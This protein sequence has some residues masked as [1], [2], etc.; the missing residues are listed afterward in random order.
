MFREFGRGVR[1][2]WRGCTFWARR[3]KL[4]LLGLVP[5][6]LAFV[7]LAGAL[8]AWVRVAPSVAT[9]LTPF[10]GL[11]DSDLIAL[12]RAAVVLALVIGAIALFVVVFAALTLL[13]G[14]PVYERISHAVEI[15]RGGITGEVRRPVVRQIGRAILDSVRMVTAAAGLGI[16]V[17]V[18]GLVPA[19][20]APLAAVVAAVG[21]GRIILTELTATPCDAR[22]MTLGQRRLLLRRH[23]WRALGFGLVTYL[24]FLIP[25]AAVLLMPAAVAGATMLARDLVGEPTP[26]L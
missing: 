8:L 23:R 1:D 16:V 7:L 13:V 10:G 14:A 3:P 12:L 20:G 17:A 26:D 6:L 25:G 5:S 9:W 2:L 15:E 4:M 21:G 24:L 19:V 11:W 18:I 22:G